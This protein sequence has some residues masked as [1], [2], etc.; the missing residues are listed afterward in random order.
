MNMNNLVNMLWGAPSQDHRLLRLH[1]VLGGDTLV[2]ERFEGIESVD[3]GGYR[4]QVTA[5]SASAHLS[6]AKLLGAPLLLQLQTAE[7]R[8]QLRPFHGHATA[9]EHLG[10]NGGM[11]RYRLTIEPW[12]AFLR[13]RKDSFAFHDLTVIEIVEQ[14]FSHYAQG[15]VAPAWRWELADSSRYLKRSLTTQYNET[16]FAFVERL[17]AEEGIFYW[18]EHSGDTGSNTFGQHTLVLADSN[19]A[20]KVDAPHSIRFHRGDATEKEDSIQQWAPLRR[21]QTASVKRASWDYRS[22]SLRDASADAPG[23]A[24]PAEDNDTAGPY[25]WADRAQ[26][27]AR[28]RQQLDALHTSSA[29]VAGAGTVRFLAP[30]QSL[31]LSGHASQADG[32]QLVL[33]VHHTARNNLGAEVQG[34]LE[35]LLGSTLSGGTDTQDNADVLY[36]NTFLVMPAD[37][38][39]RP[40]TA[41]GHGL[42]AQPVPTVTGAQ[43]A[44]ITGNGSPIHTD[45]DQRVIVQQHWQRGSNA[46]SRLDHPRQPN[47]PADA[48]AGTW[49]RV[50]TPLAGA[51][52]GSVFT[53]RVGQEVWLDYLEGDIDRPVIVG[54]LYN[55][56]GNADAPHNQ[57][58]G[59]PSGATGNAAAWF[60]GN[61]HAGVLSGLKTQDLGTSQTGTGG[62]RQLQFDDTP[63]Q[64]RV[65]LY[66][67]DYHSGLS[68]GHIKQVEDNERLADLGY[69]A[70]LATEAQG[71]VRGGKGLLVTTSASTQQMDAQT[72]VTVLQD[73]ADI[74]QSL[75]KVAQQQQAALANDT[76]TL[77]AIQAQTQLSDEL[78][79]RQDG[80][81]SSP[82]IGGGDGSAT[83]WQQP[84]LLV[85][86]DDGQINVTPKSQV[87]VSGSHTAISAK[88]DINLTAQGQFSLATAKG[89]ALYTQGK[90]PDGKAPVTATGIALHAASGKGNV[91]AQSG[92][93]HL[94]AQQG[95]TLSSGGNISVSASS[96]IQ[97]AAAGAGIIIDGGNITISASGAAN[98]LG[99][100]RVITAG[101][102]AGGGSSIGSGALGDLAKHER[103]DALCE[104]KTRGA[105]SEGNGLVEIG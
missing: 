65:Q 73:N 104:F 66:T 3:A 7:S 15:V 68:L 14:L 34:K 69:G 76:D 80:T 19:Q 64:G 71:A 60:S 81:A 51:N 49:A 97:L 101:G 89:L 38:N 53:P 12:L 78:S 1:T 91:Q 67:T 40:H 70:A 26:G 16:D 31:S 8:D 6:Q 93:L 17:L 23:K 33:A 63:Q 48:S 57:V 92:A 5:L 28:A 72:A 35:A 52:W 99:A 10:S 13:Y 75:A 82:G 39:Y 59:G 98:L 22:L 55:G 43:S 87:W 105:D 25:A 84:H 44:I 54:S 96:K 27:A 103:A 30:G 58:A 77:P 62:Y 20:F 83:A 42:R 95:V 74:A 21:W 88:A 94:N 50:T 11:A 18:F 86:G 47:A 90:A 46:A 37:H 9:V 79:A 41:A 36:H 61:D 2:P 24:A 102:G 100:Q 4:L 32:P 56:V 29:N 45:R 85:H